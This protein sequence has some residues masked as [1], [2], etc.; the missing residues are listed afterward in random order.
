MQWQIMNVW[1]DVFI[2]L[3][4]NPLSPPMNPEPQPHAAAAWYFFP[5]PNAPILRW[6]CGNNVS[7][8]KVSYI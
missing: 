3:K 5:T 8:D 7:V 2:N 6:Q 1:E 4:P